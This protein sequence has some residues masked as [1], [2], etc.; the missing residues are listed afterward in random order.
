[1]IAVNSLRVRLL[2][3]AVIWISLALIVAGT[4]L[5]ALFRDHVERRLEAELTTEVEEI[6]AALERPS[7][8]PVVLTH[9][10]SDPRYRRPYSGSYWQ[11][12]GP[13]GPLFRS[14]SLW[15]VA[16]TLPLDA[17]TGGGA[18]RRRIDGPDGQRL[19]ALERTVTLPDDPG[20]Y[21]VV[22]A[23]DERELTAADAAFT[24]TLGLSLGVLAM[25]LVAAVAIQV[26]V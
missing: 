1:M 7:A 6:A 17:A 25:A 11:V 21:R 10:P 2:A 22:A 18:H 26:R 15:D 13:E 24:R 4:L 9:Q 3:G 8:G 23:T 5:A 14:R 19:I 12:D 16:L 20:A